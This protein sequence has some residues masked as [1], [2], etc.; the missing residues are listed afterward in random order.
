MMAAF[1]IAIRGTVTQAALLGLAATIS[2]TAIVWI[3][4]LAG[5]HFGN[6]WNIEANEP[7]FQIVSAILIIGVALWMIV[8]TWRHQ[9]GFHNHSHDD[10]QR[11]I[12]TGHGV[13]MLE[14]F[15]IGMPPRF[16]LHAQ[17]QGALKHYAASDIIIETHRS[18]GSQRF[19]MDQKGNYF[20]SVED[21]PEPH[22]F[23]VRLSLSHGKHSHDYDV[24]FKEHDH[25]HIPV[26][27]EGLNVAAA[28]YQD[29]HE[30]AHAEDIRRRFADQNVT[31]G[32]IIMFGLTGGL[33]PC[34]AS[35]TILLL[36]LQ[37]K[38]VALGG[39]LV[40][41]FSI[42]LALTMVTTGAIAALSVRRI[43]RRF[44]GFGKLATRAPYFSGGLIILIGLY[45]GWSGLKAL[46]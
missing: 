6:Q 15:E 7:Y 40:L 17:S 10:E 27:Q 32:Q 21:I 38:R 28:G 9:Q 16:R 37:L 19:T 20:E 39:L 42:G 41:C 2:H 46:I 5:L 31:T 23:K 44:S 36:C 35:I 14:I 30:L 26:A 45:I 1:I 8:R 25:S 11:V 29:P 12:D 4:A 34:P 33:I 3:I 18:S 43:S 13:V 24:E 22:E